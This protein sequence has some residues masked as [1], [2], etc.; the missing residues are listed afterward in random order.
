MVV[1]Y[2]RFQYIIQGILCTRYCKFCSNAP[3]LGWFLKKIIYSYF[4]SLDQVFHFTYIW[5]QFILILH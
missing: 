2:H 4:L 1:F 5:T 3:N